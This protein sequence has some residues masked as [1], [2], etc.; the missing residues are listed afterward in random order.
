MTRIER[1]ALMPFPVEQMFALVSDIEAYPQYMDGCVGAEVLRSEGNLVEARLDLARGGVRQSFAT[2]NRSE[3]PHAIELELLEGPFEHFAG[4]WY[5]QALGES[6]CK[7]S[8]DLQFKLRGGLLGAAAGKLFESI[9]P[10]LV[11][12]VDQRARQLLGSSP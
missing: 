3:A 8:L 12:A 9:A 11:D 2:R 1:S 6:A 10:T 7:V 5:F 4:R